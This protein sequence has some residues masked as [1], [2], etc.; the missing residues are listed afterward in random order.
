MS[1]NGLC[2]SAVCAKSRGPDICIMHSTC[3][4]STCPLSG[5]PGMEGGPPA[6]PRALRSPP[7]GS[8]LGRMSHDGRVVV[9]TEQPRQARG[10]FERGAIGAAITPGTGCQPTWKAWRVS[11]LRRGMFQGRVRASAGRRPTIVDHSIGCRR[12]RPRWIFTPSGRGSS[13][14]PRLLRFHRREA[15]CLP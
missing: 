1:S 13:V 11:D 15:T 3:E 7:T 10:L 9:A 8:P 12:Q 14:T 5:A 6:A 2:P 4:R